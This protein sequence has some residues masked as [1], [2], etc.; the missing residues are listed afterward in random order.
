MNSFLR[1][2]FL[3][4]LVAASPSA[5]AQSLSSASG[6]DSGV[7]SGAVIPFATACPSGYSELT[8]AA[9]RAIIG[10]GSFYESFRGNT[11]STTYPRGAV[12]GVAAY[13]LNTNEMPSHSHGM[14]WAF[15]TRTGYRWG[16]SYFQNGECDAYGEIRCGTSEARSSLTG[17]GQAFDNRQPYIALTMC[18][19]N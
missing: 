19:K 5:F 18:R 13:V 10:S 7:P 12:G 17:G 16:R 3:A 2:I 6:G 14:A 9:G 15:S 4:S 11:F 8:Q 1:S